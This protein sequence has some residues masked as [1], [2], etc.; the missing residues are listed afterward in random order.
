MGKK[1]RWGVILDAGS[2][3][4]RLHVYRWKDP[5]KALKY[6]SAED[7]R[8]LPKL[9]TE[10]KWTKKIRPGVSTFGDRV[11]DVGPYLQQ[12]IDHALR[13][14]PRDQVQDTPIFL[15][16]TAGMRLLPQVQQTALTREICS[17]LRR[18]TQFSLPDCDL[19]IQVIK[20][21]TEG[22]YGW[23]AANYLLGGFDHP[24]HH[25]HGKGHH[26][27]GFLDMGGASAQIAFAPNATE[28]QKHAND[29]KLLRLRTLDGS[30]AEYKVFTATWLGFGVNQARERYVKSLEE[31][32]A[33]S[34]A[35]VPDPCLPKGL[36]TTLRGDPV[37]D[38]T[39]DAPTLFGTGQFDECLQLTYPLLGKDQP[40]ED[41]PCLLNGQHVPAIDF[42]VN[43]F[44]GVS[45]Y[46][47]TTHGVFGG[48]HDKAYDFATYQQRVQDFCGQDWAQIQRNLDGTKEGDAKNAQEACFKASWLINV[49]HEGIGVPRIGIE[50]LP[51][52]N[53][54]RGALEHAKEKGFIDPFQPVDKIDGIEVSWTLGK[55]VLYAAGQIPPQSLDDRYPVG[56]GSNTGGTPHDFQFAG[57]SWKPI[58]HHGNQTSDDDQDWDF[59]AEDILDRAKSKPTTGLFAFILILL[60]FL[61][62]F[63]KRDRRMRLYSRVNSVLRRPRRPGSGGGARSKGSGPRGLSGLAAKL[64]GGRPSGPAYERV[65]EEGEADRFELGGGGESD[66]ATT[67]YSETMY[68]DSSDLSR[69]SSLSSSRL[70]LSS[71]LL[72]P[73]IA[74][75]HHHL[76]LHHHHHPHAGRFDLA[77]SPTVSSS[78]LDR[79]GLAVRTESRE[80]LAL[81]SHLVAMGMGR[82]SRAGSPTRVKSPLASPLLDT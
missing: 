53:V 79:S 25:Q 47:H 39:Q 51:T 55:M 1:W 26:T 28:A 9:T 33:E 57:S 59:D 74:D 78:A 81:P 37:G 24:E 54:S 49:L 20:G 27:Y 48:K 52:A 58:N 23:I 77:S 11:G 61:Y 13:V 70:G 36:R 45:E 31:Q 8:S 35:E 46:W 3:G 66:D 44:I 34:E 7:L 43:H 16:A 64:F 22:L 63:R 2:S 14:V 17:Y 12:L 19:H 10:K 40:C 50:D 69:P 18:N 73:Q 71:G 42:D 82:R 65:M 30:P 72:T 75:H 80:R 4:T 76:H 56:F 62:F 60:L 32:Y 21:E 29:L 68:S 6:A 5:Q 38:G 41:Q 15:M 67:V